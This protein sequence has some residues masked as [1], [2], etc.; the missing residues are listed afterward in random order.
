MAMEVVVGPAMAP[1][2]RG[3]P[4]R[5]APDRADHAAEPTMSA[6]ALEAAIALAK[7][8]V[9][10]KSLRITPL[11]PLKRIGHDLFGK[12]VPTFP[13]HARRRPVLAAVA[14]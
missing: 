8:A 10:I 12:P 11:L 13:D 9:T 2:D 3:P 4:E 14:I 1:A 6:R 7:I 5:L